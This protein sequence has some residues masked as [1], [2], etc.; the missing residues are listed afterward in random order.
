MEAIL[1]QRC[2]TLWRSAQ[3]PWIL[4]ILYILLFA[5]VLNDYIRWQ[6]A[7]FIIGAIALMVVFRPDQQSTTGRY[8]LPALLS[9]MVS[10]VLPVNTVFYFTLVLAVLLAIESFAGR[11]NM[12]LLILLCLLSPFFQYIVNTFSFPLRLKLTEWVSMAMNTVGLQNTAAGNVI[13]HNGNE[14]SIDPACLGLNM[15]TTSLVLATTICVYWLKQLDRRATITTV[16]IYYVIVILLNI[17]ANML[18]I[19]TMVVFVVMPGT[20]MHELVGVIFLSGYVL[21]PLWLFSKFFFSRFSPRSDSST[22]RG[23]KGS[24]FMNYAVGILLVIAGLRLMGTETLPLT[25]DIRLEGFSITR[26]PHDVI[27]AENNEALIYFKKIKAFYSADHTPYICWQG[28][29][30]KFDKIE[31]RGGEL[32]YYK[33]ELVS[34]DD[35]LH[36]AWWY[37]SSTGQTMDQWVWRKEMLVKGAEYYVVNVSAESEENLERMMKL[38]RRMEF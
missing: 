34:G 25:A 10:V 11:T 9:A 37:Q 15:L 29:G 19:V 17:L 18:R 6:S 26:L 24:I 36:T 2:G 28:S 30:Y 8:G 21:V 22:H 20:I 5:I 35:R 33:G 4:T 16:F 38:V 12:L 23:A 32:G 7:N 1:K 3:H 31:R 14:F 13:Y 27:K